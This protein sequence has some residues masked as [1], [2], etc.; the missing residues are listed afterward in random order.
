MPLDILD[1]ISV[2]AIPVPNLGCDAI[3]LLRHGLVLIDSGLPP[4]RV[5][6]V[7]DHVL[8]EAAAHLVA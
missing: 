1:I 4:E 2:R 6:R 5:A 7:V 3:T 8:S